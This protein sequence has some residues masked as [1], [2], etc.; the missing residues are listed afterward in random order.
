MDRSSSNFYQSVNG[1]KCD[2]A[3]IYY[4]GNWLYQWELA[5]FHLSPQ[6]RLPF[7]A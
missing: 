2:K 6:N 5:I 1:D 4:Y 7:P 3:I